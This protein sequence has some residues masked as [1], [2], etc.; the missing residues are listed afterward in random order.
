VAGAAGVGTSPGLPFGNAPE[1]FGNAPGCRE[2]TLEGLQPP[3]PKQ[4]RPLGTGTGGGGLR[5]GTGEMKLK[6]QGVVEGHA[7]SEEELAEAPAR[8][9]HGLPCCLWP[10]RRRWAGPSGTCGR[11]EGT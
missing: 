6:Q 1:G 9:T 3:G 8:R 7:G 2:G 10:H 4:G 5:A 11:N